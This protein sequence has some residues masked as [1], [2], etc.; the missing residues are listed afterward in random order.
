V[1]AI[2][3]S[4]CYTTG[5]SLVFTKPSGTVAGDRIMLWACFT[6]L[7]GAGE[8]SPSFSSGPSGGGWSSQFP[9]PDGGGA[10]G[11]G[12]GVSGGSGGGAHT[13]WASAWSK[14]AGSSEPSTWTLSNSG[15]LVPI[16]GIC[17]VIQGLPSV[18]YPVDGYESG[19]SGS[20]SALTTY[21]EWPRQAVAYSY[22]YQMSYR[23]SVP[24]F[25]IARR[26][27]CTWTPDSPW[28]VLASVQNTQSAALVGLPSGTDFD[29]WE[30][31][32]VFWPYNSRKII[33]SSG[34]YYAV[35]A[36]I[37]FTNTTTLIPVKEWSREDRIQTVV[38]HPLS[39]TLI[40]VPS[41]TRS[42]YQQ[43][44]DLFTMNPPTGLHSAELQQIES[45]VTLEPEPRDRF[46]PISVSS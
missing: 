16:A 27:N 10:I 3:T 46:I 12:A 45:V 21:L 23:Y 33:S 38:E 6:T 37:W 18:L 42:M 4:T 2:L 11:Y 43:V 26:D 20:P 32:E 19:Y 17:V 40:D 24:I 5:A 31:T 39:Q 28:T 7:T 9:A 22:G 15:G 30:G 41:P 8:T 44:L 29:F 25:I 14:I 34:T 35:Y 36:L 13:S 1:S